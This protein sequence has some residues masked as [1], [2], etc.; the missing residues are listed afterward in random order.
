MSRAKRFDWMYLQNF[1]EAVLIRSGVPSH[2]A[3]TVAQSLI[4]ADLRGIESHGISRLPIYME[5]MEKGL[6]DPKKSGQIITDEGATIL[7]NGQNQF[8]AVIGLQALE[9]CLERSKQT[10]IAMTGVRHSNH[11]GACSFY[12]QKAIEAGIILLVFTNAP[13]TMAPIGGTQPF[14]GSNPLAIG[15]PTRTDPPFLLDMATTVV[16]RGKIALA[17]KKGEKI[18]LGWAIDDQGNPTDEPS[19]ALSGSILPVGGPKG[20][21]IAMFIDVLTGILT[22]A[23]FGKTVYSLY[24]NDDYPQNIGHV[25]VAIHIEHFI[26]LDL[27]LDQ[28]ADY[29]RQIKAVKRAEGIEEIYLPGELEH[30]ESLARRKQGIPVAEPIIDELTELGKRYQ[31]HFG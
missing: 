31:V 15:I 12:A 28:M 13:E 29:V 3:E 27:F 9:L 10:G 17:E 6:V 23:G 26:S 1:C 5:R 18:P 8:G 19:K 30:R 25:F 11:F 2:F 4:H 14:F 22:G 7:L 24:D 20:Y 21:G 16:A